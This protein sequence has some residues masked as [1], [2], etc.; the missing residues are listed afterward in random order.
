MSNLEIWNK[1]KRPPPTALKTIKAGRLQGMSDINPQWRL[2]VMT[3]VFGQI[4][5]GWYY[6]IVKFWTEPGAQ[7]E[8]MAFA[9]IHLFTKVDATVSMTQR[10]DSETRVINDGHWS[11]PISG[12]GGSALVAKET[13]GLRANDEAYKMAV[14]DAL[15]VAMKQLGVA[16]DIYAGLWD[17]SK[18]KDVPTPKVD[19][20]P[21]D[22][23]AAEKAI[24]AAAKK[25]KNALRAAWDAQDET[26]RMALK[27][28]LAKWKEEASKVD[29]E[30]GMQA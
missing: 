24:V 23:S 5:V 16:A 29:E 6:D 18:Y 15:S 25:G 7:G 27:G 11:A 12:I 26:V 10:F 2:E 17:G 22:T 1:V 8:L 20:K 28:K 21:I 30:I 13:A 4:G 3:E 14:T 9:H 19:D